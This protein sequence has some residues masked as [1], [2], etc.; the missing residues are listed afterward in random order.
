MNL[1]G[2]GNATPEKRSGCTLSVCSP[3]VK[4]AVAAMPFTGF[5]IEETLRWGNRVHSAVRRFQAGRDIVNSER[6][7]SR[8]DAD[9]I[10]RGIVRSEARHFQIERSSQ[11]NRL[12]DW[13]GK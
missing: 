3:V 7:I 9:S 13:R 4:S 6:R 11:R 12:A 5:D 10:W 8:R 1:L 2:K